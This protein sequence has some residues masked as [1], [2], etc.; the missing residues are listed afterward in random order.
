ML[1]IIY[2]YFYI[3]IMPKYVVT[4]EGMERRFTIPARDPF[5]AYIRMTKKIENVPSVYDVAFIY[6]DFQIIA[7]DTETGDTIA[8]IMEA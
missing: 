1:N 2:P 4:L 3:L 5:T 7:Y 6:R 8:R